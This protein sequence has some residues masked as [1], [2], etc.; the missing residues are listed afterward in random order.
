MAKA[1]PMNKKYGPSS[2]RRG[3]LRRV[4]LVAMA[5]TAL[6]GTTGCSP[7]ALQQAIPLIQ[8]AIPMLQRLLGRSNSS[9]GTTTQPPATSFQPQTPSPG[10]TGPFGTA[11]AGSCQDSSCAADALGQPRDRVQVDLG[12]G[13]TPTSEDPVAVRDAERAVEQARETL[14]QA[15]V[16]RTEAAQVGAYS[17]SRVEAAE[18]V[19]QRAEQDLENAEERLRRA[20]SAANPPS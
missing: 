13:G 16:R 3:G 19:V 20:R 12:R 1:E 6:I 5:A 11:S 14:R 9:G 7:Q 4:L 18:A 17:R 8:Q 10:T 15:R 2:G